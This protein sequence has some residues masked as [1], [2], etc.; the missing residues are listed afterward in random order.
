MFN[1]LRAHYLSLCT[2]MP[3][4][5]VIQRF[6]SF[7][8]SHGEIEVGK[9]LMDNLLMSYPKRLDLWNVFIDQLVK[10]QDFEAVR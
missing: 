5:G 1:N 9:S 7:E 3:D 10:V 4:I 8:F 6:T 2:N